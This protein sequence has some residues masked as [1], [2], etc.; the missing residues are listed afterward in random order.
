MPAIFL[1]LL[2]CCDIGLRDICTSCTI[3]APTARSRRILISEA[4]NGTKILACKPSSRA[5]V[6]IA[7]P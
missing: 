4:F 2:M 7:S 5:N 3:R 1:R 6:A